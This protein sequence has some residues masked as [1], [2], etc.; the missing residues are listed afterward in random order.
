MNDTKQVVEE[1]VLSVESTKSIFDKILNSLSA[2][3]D[4]VQEIETSTMKINQQKDNIVDHTQ[5]ISSVSEEIS[6]STEEVSASTEQV[7]ATAAT[8]VGYSENLKQLSHD[9]INQV[10]QFKIQND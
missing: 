4:K 8:F 10:N 2:L 3:N 5:N 1:Q 9:L 6:A 7:T